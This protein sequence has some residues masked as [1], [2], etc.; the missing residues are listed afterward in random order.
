MGSL[1][2]DLGRDIKTPGSEGSTPAHLPLTPEDRE[3]FTPDV[4]RGIK[5]QQA[6]EAPHLHT[7]SPPAPLTYS[8]LNQ[9]PEP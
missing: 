9:T 6:Q 5:T 8:I 3:S 4:G 1:T 7:S 2:P